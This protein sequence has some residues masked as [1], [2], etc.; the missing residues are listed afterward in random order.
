MKRSAIPL[1]QTH[2]KIYKI[3]SFICK[4]VAPLEEHC[5]DSKDST[6]QKR[7]KTTDRG[8]AIISKE[9]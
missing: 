3:T 4:H 2:C 8:N 6:F 1:Q 7:R 5:H 9:Q